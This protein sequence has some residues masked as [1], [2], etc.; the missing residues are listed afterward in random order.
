MG[1][2]KTMHRTIC[3]VFAYPG[4]CGISSIFIQGKHMILVHAICILTG[5]GRNLAPVDVVDI[6]PVF[7]GFSWIL[8]I[9]G[10]CL[11]FLNHQ[12]YHYHL[13]SKTIHRG[14]VRPTAG[15]YPMVSRQQLVRFPEGKHWW[16]KG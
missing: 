9:P 8:Y 11:G 1:V 6:F 7:I 10:G 14:V 3:S 2:G 12:Q 4:W 13:S 16:V 5:A 15:S